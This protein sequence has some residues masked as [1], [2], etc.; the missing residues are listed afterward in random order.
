MAL[1]SRGLSEIL[2]VR[3]LTQLGGMVDGR[4]KVQLEE[5]LSRRGE[6]VRSKDDLDLN[7]VCVL[8]PRNVSQ[9]F[10]QI[11]LKSNKALHYFFCNS[12][13]GIRACLVVMSWLVLF[14]HRELRI[15]ANVVPWALI[16][17]TEADN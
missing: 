11:L 17:A 16:F 14:G 13:V 1:G 2:V 9:G 7:V 3:S 15:L 8:P 6:L 5:F 4:V 10:D 12:H